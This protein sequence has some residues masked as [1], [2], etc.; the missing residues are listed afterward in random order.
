MSG[1]ADMAVDEYRKLIA[2]G[3][4]RASDHLRFVTA[5]VRSG[6]LTAARTAVDEMPDRTVL[7]PFREKFLGDISLAEGKY[8]E[9][10]AQ[11]RK[12]CRISRADGPASDAFAAEASEEDQAK[13]WAGHT[14]K[15]LRETF[16]ERRKDRKDSA[17]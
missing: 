13:A 17:E 16:R 12:A 5:L 2:D 9:A 11:Y 3:Q 8:A 6:D 10:I 15:A 14:S 4:A 7:K 1:R